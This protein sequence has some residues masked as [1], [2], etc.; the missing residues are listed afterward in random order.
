MTYTR[1]LRPGMTVEEVKATFPK[2][3]HWHDDPFDES[4]Q[5]CFMRRCYSTN[6]VMRRLDFKETEYARWTTVYF[7]VSNRLVGIYLTASAGPEIAAKDLRFTGEL[8]LPPEY[9]N[10]GYANPEGYRR[11]LAGSTNRP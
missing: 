10:H 5:T 4:K 6:R 11:T 7:D 3:M 9:A 8:P 2:E 1:Q